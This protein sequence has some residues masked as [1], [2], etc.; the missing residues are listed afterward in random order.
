[1]EE[2]LLRVQVPGLMYK[3][4]ECKSDCRIWSSRWM[5]VNYRHLWHCHILFC[6]RNAIFGGRNQLL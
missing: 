3:W 1:M 6:V 5:S 4:C 2:A